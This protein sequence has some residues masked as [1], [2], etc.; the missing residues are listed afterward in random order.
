MTCILDYGIGLL[1]Q[2]LKMHPHLVEDLSL[3]SSVHFR[4]L[5]IAYN[6]SSIEYNA[7]FLSLQAPAIVSHAQ[8]H[9]NTQNYKQ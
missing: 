1:A 5:T 9:A 6:I 8:T 4:Y 3:D 2:W 7:L